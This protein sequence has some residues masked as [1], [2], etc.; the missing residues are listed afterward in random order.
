MIKIKNKITILILGVMMIFGFGGQSVFAQSQPSLIVTPSSLTKNVGDSFDLTVKVQPNGQKVCAVEG[1]LLLS[2]LNVQKINVASGIISQTPPS[3]SNNLYFLLG[4]PKCTIQETNLF[5]VKVKAISIGQAL[6]NFKKVDIIGEGKSVSNTSQGGSYKI[7]I[8]KTVSKSVSK[9]TATGKK[10]TKPN[11]VKS[12]NCQDWNA[13]Q[14]KGCG[15]GNCLN[16]QMEQMRSR[17]CQ[18]AGCD[19]EKQTQC[20]NDRQCITVAKTQK[21]GTNKNVGLKNTS[22]L[23][24]IGSALTLGTDKA[25]V[26]IFVGLII[27]ALIISIVWWRKKK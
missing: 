1:Q 25:G 21:S 19:I 9:K 23:A 8:P 15:Q 2:K 18:P 24:S 17:I 20:V 27:L 3:F 12:C 11:V 22:F 14:N 7:I 26:G 4:I 5:T 13:W 6:A 16:T 10:L